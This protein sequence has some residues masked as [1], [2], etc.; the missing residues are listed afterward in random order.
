MRMYLCLIL[1][2][3]DV[4]GNRIT[5]VGAKM[6]FRHLEL[7]R[8]AALTLCLGGACEPLA[9]SI[10]SLLAPPVCWGV[11]GGE[12]ENSVTLSLLILAPL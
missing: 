3:F 4:I 12:R 8:L 9:L 7:R 11:R 10:L 2:S 5:Q 1:F 6:Y